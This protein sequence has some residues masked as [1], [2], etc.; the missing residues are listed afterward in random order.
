M[1]L[2]QKLNRIVMKMPALVSAEWCTIPAPLNTL[3]KSSHMTNL[4]I[5]IKNF[6]NPLWQFWPSLMTLFQKFDE[7]SSIVIFAVP[8][9]WFENSGDNFDKAWQRILES[10]QLLVGFHVNLVWIPNVK[11]Y[12]HCR[13]LYFMTSSNFSGYFFF[14]HNFPWAIIAGLPF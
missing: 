11:L 4:T 13:R 8:N 2:V 12:R 5:L 10:P 9:D 3:L 6:C 7:Q 1:Q 14:T